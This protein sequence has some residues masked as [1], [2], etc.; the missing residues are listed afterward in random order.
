MPLTADKPKP[1]VSVAGV[2]LF[3]H[4]LDHLRVAGI[5][6]I[7]ANVHYFADKMEQHILAVADDFDVIISDE[8]DVLR[9]T[10]GGLIHAKSLIFSDPFYCINADNYWTDDDEGNRNALRH[11]AENW[12]DEQ[13]D[14]LMLLIPFDKANN[15]QGHGD[16]HLGNDARLSRRQGEVPA[17]YVWTGI[18][19]MAKRL[20]V[21][22]PSTVFS[23]NVFWDRAIA[24]GRCFGIV[25][26]GHWFDVGYPEAITA[27]EVKL[28][29][30]KLLP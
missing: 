7:V 27:T 8:R 26:D 22:P 19:I 28:E 10:G 4:V 6:K 11:L 18:Q 1:M 17:P 9:D 12:N 24:N 15:T 5:S 29:Q 2:R 21:D 30:L 13:M 25:H 20:I 16:F 23:T 14:V 3:D